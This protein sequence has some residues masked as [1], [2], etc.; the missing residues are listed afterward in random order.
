MFVTVRYYEAKCKEVVC[1]VLLIENRKTL[2]CCCLGKVT[3]VVNK[4]WLDRS[5]LGVYN[6]LKEVTLLVVV[7]WDWSDSRLLYL[8]DSSIV[9]LLLVDT[10]EVVT[11]EFISKSNNFSLC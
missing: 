7:G 3:L 10:S 8:L 5:C 2:L 9:A 6:L 4:L 11:E 1:F